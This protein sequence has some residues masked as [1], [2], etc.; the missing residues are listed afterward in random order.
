LKLFFRIS[1]R[2]ETE[3]GA[4]RSSEWREKKIDALASGSESK[5]KKKR[6]PRSKLANPPIR[7]RGG[8]ERKGNVT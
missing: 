5:R 6:P 7:G 2:G 4:E 8:G 1:E 3:T